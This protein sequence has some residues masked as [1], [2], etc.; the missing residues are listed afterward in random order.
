MPAIAESVSAAARRHEEFF[1]QW[2][3]LD[4]RLTTAR[5]HLEL[6][7]ADPATDELT[8]VTARHELLVCKRE[9]ASAIA[10]ED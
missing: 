7:E 3:H 5:E 2:E 1:Q 9:L 6:L 4:A 8:I 10:S